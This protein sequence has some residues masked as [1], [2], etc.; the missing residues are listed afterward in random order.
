M[1]TISEA[2]REARQRLAER[3]SPSLDAEVLLAHVLDKPRAYVHAWPARKLDQEGLAYYRQL[4]AERPQRL[5][6]W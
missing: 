3:D 6:V 5:R 4:V 2:L 1:T